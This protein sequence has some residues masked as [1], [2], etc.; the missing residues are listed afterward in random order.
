MLA[1]GLA[2]PLALASPADNRPQCLVS[3][4]EAALE[5]NR[6]NQGG[7]PMAI[8]LVSPMPRAAHA[9]CHRLSALTELS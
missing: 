2:A 1:D 3:F 9:P 8:G 4:D 5:K 7:R 6:Q